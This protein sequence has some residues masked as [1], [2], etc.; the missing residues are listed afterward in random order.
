MFTLG[1]V[2]RNKLATLLILD[3]TDVRISRPYVL[4]T[5]RRMGSTKPSG[6]SRCTACPAPGTVTT[7]T[8]S[9]PS[10]SRSKTA[11]ASAAIAYAVAMNFA[12]RSPARSVK[13][14]TA[15]RWILARS[16]PV[17]TACLPGL[18]AASTRAR[19]LATP[20]SSSSSSSPSLDSK[21][22]ILHRRLAMAPSLHLGCDASARNRPWRYHA[23]A[24][25]ARPPFASAA[26]IAS[27]RSA[28]MFR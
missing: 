12:S 6:A 15:P 17:T 9:P 8:P 4:L 14:P 26:A 10:S 13:P 20:S 7:S 19:S 18:I 2:I 25:A 21:F 23:P 24:N 3:S 11:F 27:S 1:S 22:G 28:R 5:T 16:S